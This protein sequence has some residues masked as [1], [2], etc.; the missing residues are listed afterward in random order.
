V[1]EHLPAIYTGADCL[2]DAG[3]ERSALEAMASG[4]PVIAA[5]TMA[6][7]FADPEGVAMRGAEAR[8][9][10]VSAVDEQALDRPEQAL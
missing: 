3:D 9:R 8:R 1:L 4:L 7:A 5:A 2:I 6:A 10:V